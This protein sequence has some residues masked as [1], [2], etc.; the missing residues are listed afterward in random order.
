MTQCHEGD[1]QS[2][3]DAVAGSGEVGEGQLPEGAEDRTGYDRNLFKHW[4]AGLKRDGC[5]TRKEILISEAVEA[6]TVGA[7]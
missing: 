4:N 7:R 5:D 3:R 6:P 2:D 1:G